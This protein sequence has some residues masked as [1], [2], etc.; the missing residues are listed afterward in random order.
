MKSIS[1]ALTLLAAFLCCYAAADCSVSIKQTLGSAWKQNGRDMSQWNVQ[2]TAGS[3]AVKAIQ[4]SVTGASITQLW[5]L[6]KLSNGLYTLPDY[7]LQFGGLPAGQVHNFGYTWESASQATITV[8]SINC[9][10]PSVSPSPAAPSPS[11]SASP[12]VPSPSASAAASPSASASASP[13]AASPSASAAPASPS[14]SSS[15]APSL[16]ATPQPSTSPAGNNGCSASVELTARS[17]ANGGVW[18]NNG[19]TYQIFQLLVTNKG[20]RPV[21]GGVLTF[22]LAQSG[23]DISQWWELNRQGATSNA[24]NIAF[25]YG[26]LQVGASQGAGFVVS[27]AGSSEPNQPSF[28]LGSVSCA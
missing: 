25:N 1:L 23:S 7:R 22:D 27:V 26:L 8:T 6:T 10:S 4:L 16:V 21:N 28:T 20:Q 14:P 5:E 18:S 13:A 9:G 24:F 17:A 11:P 12:A 3:E 19:R 15:A 2:L